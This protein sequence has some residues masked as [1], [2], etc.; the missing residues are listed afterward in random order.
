MGARD[1]T[2]ELAM[3][4]MYTQQD[5]PVAAAARMAKTCLKDPPLSVSGLGPAYC[6]VIQ[7]AG[8]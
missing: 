8:V 7:W 6:T 2:R 1:N 5:S 4:H 3:G